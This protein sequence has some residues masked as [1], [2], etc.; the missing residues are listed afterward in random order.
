MSTETR[1]RL[2]RAL[3]Q[4]YRIECMIGSGAMATV[5]LAH[6]LKHNRQVA[7]KVLKPELSAAVGVE[8][9][10]REIEIA[11]SL[12][13]PH[14]VPLF[15]SGEADGLVFYVM[16]YIKGESLRD[17]LR[18]EKQLPVYD[19]ISIS[20][21]VA[22]AL[23]HAGA[24]GIVHRDI[25]PEN[26]LLLEG[27]ALVADFGIA[28]AIAEAD[29]QSL[30]Q[31]GVAIGTPAYI[32][33]EQAAADRDVDVRSDIY[34]LACV[35]YE[36]LA[37]QPPYTGPTA[38]TIIAQHMTATVPEI[39]RVRALVPEHVERAI[40]R[41]L[42]KLRADRFSTAQEFAAALVAPD[43]TAPAGTSRVGRGRTLLRTA[44][45]AAAVLVVVFLLNIGGLRD[46]LTRRGAAAAADDDRRS[47][48]VLP[49]QNV[50]SPDEEYFSDGLTEELIGVLSQLRSL[51]VAA[52]TSAFA[53]KGQARDVREIAR[54]L[55]VAN[56]LTG[57]VRKT[58]NRVRVTAQ[59]VDASSGLDIWSET[60]EERDLS[61]IFNIQADVARR[62][63]RALEANLS[64]ADSARLAR[65][66]TEN[67][68]AYTLYLKG[69]YFWGRRGERL[70][71]A[72]EY[73]NRAIAIDSQYARAYAGLAGV[74]GPLGSYGYVAPQEERERMRNAALRA[75]ELDDSLAEAH[76]VLAAY[77]HL[78]E[79]NWR[80]A[81]REFQRAIDLDPSFP[82]AHLWYGFFLETM[83]RYAEAIKERQLA[84]A[85]DP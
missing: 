20:Q 66:P 45:G 76:T 7:I 31:T 70:T 2:T 50:G 69:R 47:V 18:R 25:K 53:F 59:L 71:T 17:R 26:I 78:Y 1:E 13:S 14:I 49:F 29:A 83:G 12:S 30:T 58:E 72:I 23:T 3:A 81:E 75:V 51:R 84:R 28:R 39:R 35:L 9:F 48:A 24:K 80:D 5:Y 57:S 21:Q 42:S 73:F 15:D 40:V 62:I 44:F 63:A 55:S 46:R 74:F 22:R 32:S 27:D 77:H 11:A 68:E 52:H 65:K 37:G 19:A 41:A 85:L 6:D 8:R 56:V 79:W 64:V 38:Q 16:P 34:A 54:A 4:R 33:P 10:L 60:Y 61:D 36:M 67:L 43:A 82:T